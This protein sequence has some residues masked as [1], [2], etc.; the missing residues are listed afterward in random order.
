MIGEQLKIAYSKVVGCATFGAFL[1]YAVLGVRPILEN[2][3][4][5]LAVIGRRKKFQPVFWCC[6]LHI[7]NQLFR[8]RGRRGLAIL[9]RGKNFLKEFFHPRWRKSYKLYRHFLSDI[10]ESVH[11]SAWD[12]DEITCFGEVCFIS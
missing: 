8:Y 2:L 6:L 12:V 9:H 5:A 3:Y 4:L 1:S 7:I 10:L 11:R